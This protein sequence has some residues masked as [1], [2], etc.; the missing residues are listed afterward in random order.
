MSLINHAKDIIQGKASLGQKRSKDWKKTRKAHLKTESKCAVC[1]GSKK[2]EVHH[3]IPFNL[4]PSFELCPDNLITL[5]ENKK[6]GVNCHL[7]FGHLG[8]YSD[9]NPDC[10][11]DV[12]NWH[13]KINKKS[14]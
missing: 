5:C 14:L 10:L 11:Q 6:Y 8:K 9:W 2:L 12:E 7:L 1:G 3:I 4:D 13:V